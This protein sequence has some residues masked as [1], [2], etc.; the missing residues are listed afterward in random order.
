[1]KSD[2][3]LDRLREKGQSLLVEKG[4]RVLFSSRE[5]GL[6][7]LVTCLDRHMAGMHRAIAADKV[8]GAAAAQLFAYGQVA[9]VCTFVASES[10]IHVLKS[11]GIALH[12]RSVVPQI[13]DRRGVDLCPME[14]LALSLPD[15]KALF[16][17]L[18]HR[19]GL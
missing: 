4:G 2:R 18:K 1:M 19:M 15:G 16:L 17:E 11:A 7:P 12:A 14:Q 5:E 9:D 8:V 3:M 10:A 13:L 6:R